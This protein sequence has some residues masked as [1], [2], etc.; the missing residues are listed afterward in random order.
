MIDLGSPSLG[1]VRREKLEE[2][3]KRR[4]GGA[5]NTKIET[6]LPNP[7]VRIIGPVNNRWIG[8][9]RPKAIIALIP[10]SPGL[11]IRRMYTLT[12]LSNFVENFQT[13]FFFLELN[14]EIKAESQQD[15][16]AKRDT[17]K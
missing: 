12:E 8:R 15:E 1:L 13:N 10:P 7:K 6:W 11:N 16:R 4:R 14:E 17:A 9:I 5:R 3:W 2:E